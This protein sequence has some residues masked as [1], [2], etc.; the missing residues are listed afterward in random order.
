MKLQYS[1]I[2]FFTMVCSLHSEPIEIGDTKITFEP[3]KNFAPLSDEVI[4]KNWPKKKK[5]DF[6]IGT[7]SGSTNISY[8][9]TE[10]ELPQKAMPAAKFI[11][12]QLF[13]KQIEGIEW[14][15][16]DLI[17]LG[18]QKWLMLEMLSGTEEIHNIVLITGIGKKTVILNLNSTTDEFPKFEKQLRASINSI[19][20]K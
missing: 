12:A 4:Q 10:N 15:E 13:K 3:P 19:V 1:I 7:L 16:N 2:A 6:V 18:G 11:F 9:V 14:K 17:E 8:T 20:M 5:P